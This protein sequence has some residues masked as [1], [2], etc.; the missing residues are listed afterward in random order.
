MDSNNIYSAPVLGTAFVKDPNN[1]YSAPVLGT[2]F[3][4]DPNNMIGFGT[5][6]INWKAT[7]RKLKG[8]KKAAK[9][10]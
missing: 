1:I 7:H 5:A 9:R 8:Y 4:K 2:A 3:V 10:K 6:M